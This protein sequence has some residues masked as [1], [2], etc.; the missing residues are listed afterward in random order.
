MIPSWWCD[1]FRN[2]TNT[3][4]EDKNRRV[5]AQLANTKRHLRCHFAMLVLYNRRM[6]PSTLMDTQDYHDELRL[7]LRKY[8]ELDYIFFKDYFGE[9]VVCP[10]LSST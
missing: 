1:M 7:I 2:N 10:E 5:L 3:K 9:V 6:G 4:I 8:P